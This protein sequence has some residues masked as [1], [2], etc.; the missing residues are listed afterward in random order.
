MYMPEIGRWGVIDP[1][2]ERY[3]RWSPYNYCMDNPVRF[4][5]PDGMQVLEGAAAQQAFR[6]IKAQRIMSKLSDKLVAQ[7]NGDV[8]SRSD[9]KPDSNVDSDKLTD[10]DQNN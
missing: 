5:D 4:I 2:A 8:T 6:K 7:V 9:D 10:Q 1:M 3:R